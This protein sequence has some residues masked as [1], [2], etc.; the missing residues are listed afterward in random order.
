MISEPAS[1]L[2]V[3]EHPESTDVAIR[4][5]L[6]RGAGKICYRHLTPN[7]L[8]NLNLHLPVLTAVDGLEQDPQYPSLIQYFKSPC[9][10]DPL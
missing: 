8:T 9:R 1:L 7:F 10:T 6:G 5:D 2:T 3:G 4:N